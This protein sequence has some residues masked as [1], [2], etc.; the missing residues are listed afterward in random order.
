MPSILIRDLSQETKDALKR[1][2]GL[3]KRSMEE[4]ARQILNAALKRF[5]QPKP[6]LSFGE[7]IHARFAA[8][9]GVELAIPPR[10]PMR[11]LPIF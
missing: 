6:E 9:G 4:E 2:S 11:P 10:S 7:K 8:L 5:A 1:R 3:H